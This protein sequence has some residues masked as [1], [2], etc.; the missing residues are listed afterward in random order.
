MGEES[1]PFP[2][3]LPSLTGRLSITVGLFSPVGKGIIGQ[4]KQ[5]GEVFQAAS[6]L[7]P[8]PRHNSINP[9]VHWHGGQVQERRR[10]VK[11]RT[12]RD[13]CLGRMEIEPTMKWRLRNMELWQG[14]RGWWAQRDLIFGNTEVV[15][16][17]TRLSQRDIH[18][19]TD[20]VNVQI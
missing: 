20:E 11:Q 8:T 18:V 3:F 13:K 19:Q 5:E 14:D 17:Q 16:R 7:N 9:P 15:H 4:W 10:A 12:E 2:S 6:S 1:A